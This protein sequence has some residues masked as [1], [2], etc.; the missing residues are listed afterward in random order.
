MRRGICA[1]A[2]TALL[3]LAAFAQEFVVQ[4]SC[5]DGR[6][7]GAYELRSG[8]GTLR[9]VGAF[10][11][12]RRTGSFLFWSSDGAR[13]AHLPFEDDRLTGTLALWYPPTPRQAE[14]RHRVEATY[15]AGR[16]SGLKRSWYPS[17]RPRAE[18]SYRSGELVEATAFTET[19]DKVPAAQVGADGRARRGG[20]RRAGGVAR[21]DGPVASPAVRCR[22]RSQGEGARAGCLTL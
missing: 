2:A 6:P 8:T 14:G 3:P 17:G 10:A 21:S 20:R 16:L 1:L 13:V 7:H 22:C 9:V 18:Y 11:Q 15:A 19:G 4:G 12:G 5:R